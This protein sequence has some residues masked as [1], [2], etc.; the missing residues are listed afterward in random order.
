[1]IKSAKAR[2]VATAGLRLG[3]LSI[4]HAEDLVSGT[5]LVAE[6]GT[7]LPS[8]TAGHVLGDGGEAADHVPETPSHPAGQGIYYLDD[9][10]RHTVAS[11]G[12]AAAEVLGRK[13]ITLRMPGPAVWAVAGMNQMVGRIR[14]KTPPLNLDKARGTVNAEW[15]CSSDKAVAELGYAPR[16]GIGAGLEH[17]IRWYRDQGW[18]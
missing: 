13:A 4:I 15:W 3:G 16:Y 18:L 12:H 9:L 17:T 7:P 2:V 8:D 14:G 5:I 11:F 10:E 6:R 1:M